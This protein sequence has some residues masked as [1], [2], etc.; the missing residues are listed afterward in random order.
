MQLD[1]V[2]KEVGRLEMDLPRL[3][4]VRGRWL[5]TRFVAESLSRQSD[6][7]VSISKCALC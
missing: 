1:G 7:L 2:Q 6:S 3:D 5:S 4:Q